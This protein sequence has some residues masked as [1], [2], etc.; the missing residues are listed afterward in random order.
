MLVTADLQ[1]F[2]GSNERNEGYVDS[3]LFSMSLL[4]A[5]KSCGLAAC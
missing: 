1:A 3:G 5:M 4:Y 2:M